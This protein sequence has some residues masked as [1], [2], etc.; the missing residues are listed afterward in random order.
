MKVSC[1]NFDRTGDIMIIPVFKDFDKAPNNTTVGLGRGP[2]IAVK[3]A[4]A[5]DAISGKVGE[6]LSVWTKGCTVIFI[7]VGKKGKL[8]HKVARDTGAKC[9]ASLSKDLGNDIVIRFTSGWS[10]ENMTAFAEGM[11][12]RDYQFDKYQK[13]DEENNHDGWTLECQAHD[14]H[15]EALSESIEKASLVTTGVH[16]SRT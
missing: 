16:L 8:T 7:G 4:A 10:T 12:L 3:A 6:S 9:L 14:R 1:A 15:L 13:K 2:S 11:M 5:S